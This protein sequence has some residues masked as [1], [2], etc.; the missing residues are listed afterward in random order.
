MNAKPRRAQMVDA[1]SHQGVLW[2]WPHERDRTISDDTTLTRSMRFRVDPP[3]KPRG[4]VIVDPV[5]FAAASRDADLLAAASVR[6]SSERVAVVLLLLIALFFIIAWFAPAGQ[7]I[8]L[9]R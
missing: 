7:N 6:R 5:R 1:D 4:A 3:P 2:A 9:G 8:W